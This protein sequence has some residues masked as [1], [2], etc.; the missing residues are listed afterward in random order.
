MLNKYQ[1]LTCEKP[2][3]RTVSYNLNKLLVN[4]STSIVLKR[5]NIHFTL[6]TIVEFKL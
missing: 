6:L 4:S 1:T 3:L 2:S 5:N